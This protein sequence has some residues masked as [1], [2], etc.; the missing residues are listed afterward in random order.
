SGSAKLF[1][2]QAI[3]LAVKAQGFILGKGK[4]TKLVRKKELIAMWVQGYKNTLR[5]KLITKCF[6]PQVTDVDWLINKL[7]DYFRGKTP[8]FALAGT[9]AAFL[10]ARFYR[11][12][13]VAFFADQI[14]ENFMKQLK[15]FPDPNGP[16]VFL[17]LFT[18]NIIAKKVGD[19]P[20][21]HPLIIY[22]ELLNYEANRT[23]E[24]ADIIYKKYLKEM[25]DED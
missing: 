22:A 17:K 3:T 24:T 23:A 21:A 14:D 18:Q 6:R 1:D 9:Q 13:N 8:R 2:V 10:L 15:L 12:E 20:L 5:P 11:D 7:T 16:V 19:V 4:Y 25:E